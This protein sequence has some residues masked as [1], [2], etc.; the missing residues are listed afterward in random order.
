MTWSSALSNNCSNTWWTSFGWIRGD[1][2]GINYSRRQSTYT[3]LYLLFMEIL[4]MV[5]LP[6]RIRSLDY[7]DDDLWQVHVCRL[8]FYVQLNSHFR[9]KRVICE[10]QVKHDLCARR[11]YIYWTNINMF[12]HSHSHHSLYKGHFPANLHPIFCLNFSTVLQPE[13]SILT[14][15][16]SCVF[17]PC[18]PI[19]CGFYMETR[20]VPL[21]LRSVV[22]K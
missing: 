4:G 10:C 19:F 3:Y 16:S 14:F 7:S 21:A 2:C 13:Y 12:C 17:V 18:E 1:N 5:P 6:F 15:A 22:F 9:L 8:F 11:L 20:Y